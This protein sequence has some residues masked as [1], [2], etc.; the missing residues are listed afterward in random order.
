M[1]HG[2]GSRGGLKKR[3]HC[4]SEEIW[5]ADMDAELNGTSCG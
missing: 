5:L 3:M 1:K 2:H 4:P